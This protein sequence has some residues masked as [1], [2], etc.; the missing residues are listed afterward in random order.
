MF[1]F[2][3]K[4]AFVVA[5]VF[6]DLFALLNQFSLSLSDVVPH[7]SLAE[8]TSSPLPLPCLSC[9]LRIFRFALTFPLRIGSDWAT[10][11]F[12][13]IWVYFFYD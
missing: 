3:K 5:L 11:W 9:A 2:E 10:D 12:Q 13:S 7:L 4:I 8:A 6:P 1:Y